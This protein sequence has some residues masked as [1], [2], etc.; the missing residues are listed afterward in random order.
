MLQKDRRSAVCTVWSHQFGLELRLA[1]DVDSLPRTQ[2]CASHEDLA[3]LQDD[4]RKALEVRGW[5][6]A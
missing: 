3:A 6:K 1:I 4:W 5:T 2:V